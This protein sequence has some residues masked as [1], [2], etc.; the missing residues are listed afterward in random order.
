MGI[1][2]KKLHSTA[3][4]GTSQSLYFNTRSGF[5]A[6]FPILVGLLPN[7]LGLRIAVAIFSLPAYGIMIRAMLA[8]PGTRRR[9]LL[10]L[11]AAV[12]D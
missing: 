11:T 9:P 6:L 10:V 8:L 1:F 5:G 3:A 7:R 2:M 4:G 12:G